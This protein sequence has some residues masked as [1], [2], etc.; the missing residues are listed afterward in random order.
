MDWYSSFLAM[1]DIAPMLAENWWEKSG[2]FGIP[3]GMFFLFMLYYNN[4]KQRQNQPIENTST[5]IRPRKK[6]D[7]RSQT[8]PRTKP[9]SKKKKPHSRTPKKEQKP[10]VPQRVPAGRCSKCG[11]EVKS[12]NGKPRCLGCGTLHAK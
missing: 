10:F 7:K 12:W 3:I 9:K 6:S 5:Q 2:P 8:T 4:Q 1:P 11:G